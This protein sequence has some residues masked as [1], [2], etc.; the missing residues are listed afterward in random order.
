[1]AND[2]ETGGVGSK[3][4]YTSATAGVG[5]NYAAVWRRSRMNSFIYRSGEEINAGDQISYHGEPGSVEFVVSGRVGDP[6][7]DWYIETYPTG[8][9]MIK[10][11]I[12]RACV[13][14]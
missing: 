2:N 4:W 13:F 9:V 1:M 6:A 14:N 8:G 11:R 10:V 7:I 5:F 12:F 3:I